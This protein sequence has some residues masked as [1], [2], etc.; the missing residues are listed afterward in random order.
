MF[1]TATPREELVEKFNEELTL[2][3]LPECPR[4]GTQ[5]EAVTSSGGSS[6]QCLNCGFAPTEDEIDYGL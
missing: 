5:M 3:K 4:C 6:N 1:D 2:W